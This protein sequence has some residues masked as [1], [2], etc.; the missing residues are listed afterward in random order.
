MSLE[1]SGAAVEPGDGPP[2]P[3][4]WKPI[5]VPGR[6]SE[7]AGETAVAYRAVFDDPR[8]GD[9][10]H[11]VLRLDGVYAEARVWLNGQQIADHDAYF[12]P[13]RVP[14]PVE[15]QNELVVEC[16]RPTDRFGGIYDTD[17]VPDDLCVPGIWWDGAVETYPDPYIAELNVAPRVDSEDAAVAV[18]ATIV[19]SEP[20]DDRVTLSLRPTGDVRGGGTMNRVRVDTDA[21]QETIIHEIDVRDPSLWWPHNMGEQ[22]RYA[23]RAKVDG[24]ERTTVTGLRSVTYG[25]EGLLIN[26]KR[27][28]ARGINLIRGAPEDIGRAVEANANLVRPHAHA[29]A[30]DVYEA[31]DEQGL[32][33][34]QDLPLTGPGAFDT[35]RGSDLL[36]RLVR[37]R[38]R[39]PSMAAVSVHGD[40]VEDYAAGLGSGVIDRLR[41]RWRAWRAEY[42]HDPARSVADSVDEVPVF[43]VVGPAGIDPDGATMYPGWTFGEPADVNWLCDRYGVGDV[44]SEFGAGAVT[45][46]SP[47]ESTDFD[48]ERHDA[49]VDGGLDAAQTRQA[50]VIGQVAETLRRRGPHVVAVYALRDVDGAG[51]G[52][53]EQDGTPKAAFDRLSAAFEPTQVMLSDP[54]PGDSDLVV[55]HDRPVGGTATV[56]WDIDGEREQTEIEVDPHSRKTVR[57][58]TLT[59]E[60][61]VTLAI[62][63]DGVVAKNRYSI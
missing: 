59:A 57:T 47:S 5:D 32:L 20:L 50:R 63:I 21:G 11:A 44:V 62:A 14:L 28:P 37:A 33:V 4:T 45:G 13:L 42:D 38:H 51:M 39:H 23:V 29:L 53:L 25:D 36:R 18:A 26:G 15:D 6:P 43:P 2:A 48:Q 8:S 60:S 31:C 30:P 46:S 16:R 56:E 1:W 12:E 41:Y 22:P 34:W 49:R 52:V 61:D 17:R 24:V 27:V 54:A 40:P 58:L 7:F 55:L 9:E 19:T 35:D 10:D 3:E